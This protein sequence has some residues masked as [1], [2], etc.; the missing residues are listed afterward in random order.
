MSRCVQLTA[1]G[2]DSVLELGSGGMRA[3]LGATR[4]R[5]EGGLTAG[6]VA[7]HELGHPGFGDTSGGGVVRVR[8]VRRNAQE[9]VA[10]GELIDR[11]VAE[12]SERRPE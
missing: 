10:T 2:E 5:L 9:D 4:L 1:Q 8:D 6:A 11:L 7:G 3:G 12:V